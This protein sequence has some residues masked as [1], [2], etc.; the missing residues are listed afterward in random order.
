MVGAWGLTS[1]R[2]SPR[3]YLRPAL[4]PVKS[5]R[6]PKN[7]TPTPCPHELKPPIRTEGTIAFNC[8]QSPSCKAVGVVLRGRRLFSGAGG[9]MQVC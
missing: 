2:P 6:G 7:I 1:P 8:L 5:N 4:D 3:P 9:S